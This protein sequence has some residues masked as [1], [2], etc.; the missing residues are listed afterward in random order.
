MKER[1]VDCNSNA[2]VEGVA[3]GANEGWNLAELVDLKVLCG[4]AL[5]RF[6]FHDVDAEAIRLCDSMDCSGSGVTLDNIV[7]MMY[8]VGGMD[9]EA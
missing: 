4:D 6:S 2:L 8:Q 1:T 9:Q 5:C 7:S 3:I